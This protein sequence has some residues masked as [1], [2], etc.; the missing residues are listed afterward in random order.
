MYH[1]FIL[2]SKLRV[3]RISSIK[4]TSI[5]KDLPERAVFV[6]IEPIKKTVPGGS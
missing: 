5:K 4:N 2:I 6:F 1:Y 3:V